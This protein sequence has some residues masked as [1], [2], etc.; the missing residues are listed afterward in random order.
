[1]SAAYRAPLDFANRCFWRKSSALPLSVAQNTLD[2]PTIQSNGPEFFLARE[3]PPDTAPS[4]RFAPP[5][6]PASP[7]SLHLRANDKGLQLSCHGN[8]LQ[9]HLDE[10][11]IDSL[12]SPVTSPAAAPSSP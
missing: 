10:Q 2:N 11:E 12:F 8:L 1:M 7:P 5:P 4:P 3:W 9:H 6:R